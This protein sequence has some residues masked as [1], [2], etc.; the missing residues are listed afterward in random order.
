MY[1]R[2]TNQKIS[3]TIDQSNNSIRNFVFQISNKERVV[4]IRD[5]ES[6]DFDQEIVLTKLNKEIYYKENIILQSLYKSASEKK[7][8]ASAIIEFARIYGFQVD[9]Q[10][11]IRKQDRFQI[12]YEVFVDENKK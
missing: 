4:L 5:V 3:F 6:N 10:R 2:N 12:M 8:P 1:N 11:D 9:F 7:I